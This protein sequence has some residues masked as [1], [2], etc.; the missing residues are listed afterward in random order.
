MFIRILEVDKKV[1]LEIKHVVI[2]SSYFL[3]YVKDAME[4]FYKSLFNDVL[5]PIQCISVPWTLA[6]H[7]VFSSFVCYLQNLFEVSEITESNKKEANEEGAF[8]DVEVS[9]DE[10]IC[11]D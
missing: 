3:I 10:D 2:F 7:L 4:F 1:G 8:I 11:V 9:N 5:V 6:T